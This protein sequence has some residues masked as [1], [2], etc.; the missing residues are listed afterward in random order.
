MIDLS[1]IAWRMPEWISAYGGLRTDNEYFAQSPFYDRHSNN[2]LLK[3]QTQFSTLG[4]LQGHLKKMRGIEFVIS[5]NYDPDAWVIYKQHRTSEHDATILAAYFIANE[6]IY[7]A[8][9]I[10][11]VIASRM[12]NII[13]SLRLARSLVHELHQFSSDLG[14]SYTPTRTSAG[15]KEDT[16]IH[17]KSNQQ[18]LKA[19]VDAMRER[20]HIHLQHHDSL[21]PKQLESNTQDKAK[22]NETIVLKKKKKTDKKSKSPSSSQ[23]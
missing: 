1:V 14:Y 15:S 16:S 6:S 23:P 4:D 5:A 11:A 7:M 20:H 22:Q 3:M 2:Q 9:S 12:L 13:L 21:V 17:D 18:M 8:P 19:L 10:H